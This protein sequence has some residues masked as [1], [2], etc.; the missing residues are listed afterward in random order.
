[1]DGRLFNAPDN[2]ISIR[3][4]RHKLLSSPLSSLTSSAERRI[5]SSAYYSQI[6]EPFQACWFVSSGVLTVTIH[7]AVSSSPENRILSQRKIK[8]HAEETICPKC[9]S[10]HQKQRPPQGP[11]EVTLEISDR[12]SSR[13]LYKYSMCSKDNLACAARRE[14]EGCRAPEKVVVVVL[15]PASRNLKVWKISKYLKPLIG[16]LR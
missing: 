10:Q 5:T 14:N 2:M 8:G 16:P 7:S 15:N 3:S 1:M 9:R 11:K 4:P 13:L 6:T 12:L